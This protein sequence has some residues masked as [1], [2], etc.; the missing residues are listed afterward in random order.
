MK[1]AAYIVISLSIMKGDKWVTIHRQSCDAT[2]DEQV[3]KEIK[4]KVLASFLSIN[5]SWLREREL[6]V[7]YKLRIDN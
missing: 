3:Q 4:E 7:C 1:Q 2:L 6:D 5:H